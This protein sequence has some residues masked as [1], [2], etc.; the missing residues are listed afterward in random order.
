ML[1]AAMQANAKLLDL[2]ANIAAIDA[3]TRRAADAGA[4]ILVT[5]ELFVTGY[6]P[7]RVRAALRPADLSDLSDR[8][9]AIAARHGIGLVYSL[10]VVSDDGSWLIGARLVDR[11]G[12]PRL[13]YAKVHLFGDEEKANF[14]P[15]DA[16]PEIAD[17][18]GM[19]VSLAICYDIE[20][21]EVARAATRSG[22]DVIL[23]PTAVLAGYTDV[24][25]LLVRSRALENHIGI[26]YAN[27]S[28]IEADNEFCGTSIVVGPDG[29]ALGEA[30]QGESELVFGEIDRPGIEAQRRD[31]PYLENSRPDTYRNWQDRVSLRR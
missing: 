7:R 29:V 14:A 18:D 23:V 21:P 15:A 28:G 2:E 5:P 9:D 3:A 12:V 10:P 27:H 6:S 19:K 24:P 13:R 22:A 16:P 4:S 25:R 8:I 20:H 31:V 11:D 30:S 26:V 1:F 17:I